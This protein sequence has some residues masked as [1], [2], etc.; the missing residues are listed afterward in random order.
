MKQL[1]R[2]VACAWDAR[3]ATAGRLAAAALAVHLAGT[4]G[5]QWGTCM[6]PPLQVQPGSGPTTAAEASKRGA[7]G[8]PT[9]AA[10]SKFR[11]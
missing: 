1:L 7:R 10:S 8:S 5:A 9:T 11:K 6:C 3:Q 4:T 2:S